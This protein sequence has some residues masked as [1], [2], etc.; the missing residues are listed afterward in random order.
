[1]N[2]RKFDTNFFERYAR[3]TLTSLLGDRYGQM[4]NEDRPDLQMED[5]SLGIE[6]TRA[7]IGRAHV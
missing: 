2:K 5:R 6:V 3:I 7:K 1:M 4:L